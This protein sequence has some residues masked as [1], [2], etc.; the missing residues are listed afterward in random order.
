M[1][2]KES[3]IVDKNPINILAATMRIYPTWTALKTTFPTTIPTTSTTSTTTTTTTTT[4]P[5][6]TTTP[7]TTIPTT[8]ETTTFLST[9]PFRRFFEFENFNNFDSSS[10]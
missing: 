2:H 3:F 9:A 5:L 6:P 10:E 1:C 7:P 4:T 8:T